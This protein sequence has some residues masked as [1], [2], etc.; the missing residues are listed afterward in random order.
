MIVII[1]LAILH[2]FPGIFPKDLAFSGSS[3]FDLGASLF[4]VT[5]F[6]VE[7]LFRMGAH[8][9]IAG[10]V[11]KGLAE[12]FRSPVRYVDVVC[13]ALE[14]VTLFN[15]LL[16]GDDEWRHYSAASN[17]T[18]TNATTFWRRPPENQNAGGFRGAW[19]RAI[20]FAR[21]FKMLKVRFP[22]RGTR[23]FRR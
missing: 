16:S 22:A 1:F 8:V 11:G 4:L 2:D 6:S 7:L 20:R 15:L 3:G 12:C 10:R 17:A 18:A 14:L 5:I 23:L 19:M 9:R 13:I 21:T